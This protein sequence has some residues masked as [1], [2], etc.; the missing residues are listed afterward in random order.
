MG[1]ETIRNM[2][3]EFIDV[4]MVDVHNTHKHSMVK[5]CRFWRMS[6][7][8]PKLFLWFKLADRRWNE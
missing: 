5:E 3:D 7:E 6:D 8:T 1:G 2:A 4:D